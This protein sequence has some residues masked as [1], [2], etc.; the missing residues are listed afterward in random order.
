MCAIL[1]AACS[2]GAR[3]PGAEASQAVADVAG[4]AISAAE[5][6]SYAARA[7]LDRRAALD[8]LVTVEVLAQE[9]KR[10]GIVAGPSELDE[11]R[12][13]AVRALLHREFEATHR[14]EDIPHAL[15][16]ETYERRKAFFV[17]PPI[18]NVH[19]VLAGEK[20]ARPGSAAFQRVRALVAEARR[21]ALSADAIVARAEAMGLHVDRNLSTFVGDPRFDAQWVAVVARGAF[22]AG[23]VSDPFPTDAFGWHA[24]VFL[25][26]APARNTSLQESLSEI[27]DRLFDEYRSAEFG[28]W[29]ERQLDQHKV[30]RR[31]E[32]LARADADTVRTDP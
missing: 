32:L 25:E 23:A 9:A 24:V 20:P 1:L 30:V 6:A 29:L 7:G 17:H 26:E 10:R 13:A 4:T 3:G 28:K 31:P 27:R 16:A 14:K 18:R 8:E 11:A 15:L 19:N 22:V 12:R 5:V 2:G 21:D